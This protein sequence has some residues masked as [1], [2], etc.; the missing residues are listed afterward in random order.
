MS[1]LTQYRKVEDYHGFRHLFFVDMTRLEHDEAAEWCEE[2]FGPDD[3]QGR[4]FSVSN[5]FAFISEDDA[6]VFR[7]RWL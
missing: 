3:M 7:M 1:K 4:W 6:F 2:L 5:L